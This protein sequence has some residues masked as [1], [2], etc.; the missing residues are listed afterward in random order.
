MMVARIG[1]KEMELL[2]WVGGG[3]RATDRRFRLRREN[4]STGSGEKRED[5]Y[6]T[7]FD[8]SCSWCF[9]AGRRRRGDDPQ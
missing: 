2:R 6:E 1:I 9:G 7:S 4:T 3:F 8:R 5:A